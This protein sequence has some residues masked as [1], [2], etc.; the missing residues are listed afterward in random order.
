MVPLPKRASS[1]AASSWWKRRTWTKRSTS[2][3]AFPRAAGARW[4]YGQWWR[5]RDFLSLGLPRGRVRGRRS[6]RARLFAERQT[7]RT[8]AALLFLHAFLRRRLASSHSRQHLIAVKID[9]AALILLSR[10]VSNC[11]CR[12]NKNPERPTGGIYAKDYPVFVV[13]WQS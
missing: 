2:R 11:G 1:L 12:S 3:P 13:R 7:R 9:H 6:L 4:R 10:P 8:A 5:L